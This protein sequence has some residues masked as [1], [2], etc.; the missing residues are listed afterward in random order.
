MPYFIK[1]NSDAPFFFAGL[2]DRWKSPDQATISSVTIITTEPNKLME[3]IH[4]RMPVILPQEFIP[5]W[6]SDEQSGL[7]ELQE[8]LNPYPAEEMTAYRVS[9]MVNFSANEG[10]ELAEEIKF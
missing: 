5:L 2:W 10:A 9:T 8:G 4:N 1:M 7:K 6:L 3:S